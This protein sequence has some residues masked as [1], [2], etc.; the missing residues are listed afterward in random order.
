MFVK[1]Q[2][3][4]AKK[5]IV[6]GLVWL[7]FLGLADASVH[8][9]LSIRLDNVP[10][11]EALESIGR[12]SGVNF[13]IDAAMLRGAAPVTVNIHDQE[14]GRAADRI[15]RPRGFGMDVSGKERVRVVKLEPADEFKAKRDNVFE[16]ARK[17]V[18]T[19]EGKDRVKIEFEVQGWCD[20]TVAIEDSDGRILRHLASGVLG[21]RAPEPFRWNSKAQ[22]L[23][24][25]GKD[26]EGKYVDDKDSVVVRVSLGLKPRFERTLFWSPKKR[27]STTAPLLHAAPEG[28]YVF[29]G[30]GVDHLRLFTHEGEY[31]KTLVPPPAG[32]IPEII[33]LPRHVVPQT[34]RKMP[35]MQGFVQSTLLTSGTS[36]LF[37]AGKVKFG[38]TTAARAMAVQPM[39]GAPSRI[40][41]GF[42]KLNRLA[43]NGTSGGLPF[44]G[45]KIE[46]YT[47]LGGMA[48]PWEGNKKFHMSPSSMAF[49][50]DGS[51]LY[52]TG[53]MWTKSRG[54]GAAYHGVYRLNYETNEK[55]KVFA[56]VMTQDGAGSGDDRFNVP[57]SVA[58]D[59][60]GRVYVSDYLNDRIQV[61]TPDGSLVKSLPVIRPA[62]VSVHAH[63]SEIYAFSWPV[64]GYPYKENGKETT[65]LRKIKPTLTRLG[66]L[67]KPAG[68]PVRQTLPLGHHDSN[69]LY[70]FGQ[71]YSVAL[72]SWAEEPTLWA[73]G[74]RHEV[75]QAAMSWNAGAASGLV[76][77]KWMKYGVR[78]LKE[79]GGK[80]VIK[81]HFGEEAAAKLA[82]ISPPSFAAQRLYF[83]PRNKRLYLGEP[84]G[85]Q[86]SFR[87]LVE[88]DPE[89]GRQRIVQLPFDAEDMAF[90]LNGHAYLRTDKLIARY[91]AA[92]WREIPWDYGEKH[93]G[94]G[95]A[96][97]GGGRSG[98]VISALPLPGGAR[99]VNWSMGGMYVSPKKLLVV[100]VTSKAPNRDLSR[101]LSALRR[102]AKSVYE[103]KKQYEPMAFPGRRRWGEVHVWNKHGELVIEDAAPGLRRLDGIAISDRDHSIYAYAHANRM[104]PDGAPYF[105]GLTGTAM[106]FPRSRVRIRSPHHAV[107]PLQKD[108]QPAR[109]MELDEGWVNGAEWFY[110]GIGFAG[111]NRAAAVI[112]GGCVCWNFRGSFDYFER[113]FLPELD[114]FSVAVVDPAGN[115][116]VRIGDYGN[117]DE[118]VPLVK[119]GGPPDPRS[120]GGDETSFIRPA[121]LATHTDR[122]LFVADYGNARII[123]VKLGYHTEET[124]ALKNMQDGER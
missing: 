73:V 13:I 2:T 39:P 78:I 83:N 116:I 36:A 40:A 56:G 103:E 14:A 8:T 80:W 95:F 89:T 90:D 107:V 38:M 66:T 25:D 58:V 77:R 46:F 98:N 74:R 105:R 119:E 19:R 104:L 94:V 3:A 113:S 123:S 48:G 64:S 11:K 53:Y 81:R 69:H 50:P 121:Y 93:D 108:E 91:D 124:V 122:R 45:P 18:V 75:T 62:K 101:Q 120:I 28:V 31:A 112:G 24:W 102:H 22:K 52:L 10:L 54:G 33:G 117:V 110:G 84:I 26:D 99:P 114:L 41:L 96:R 70:M 12:K 17:P 63:T 15:L 42:I 55:P 92:N 79:E 29:E 76:R 97:G 67:K 111:F 37:E 86:K 88:I 59:K 68:D 44:E 32:T 6:S 109:P 20:A 43:G 49:S 118:G 1:R 23:V 47:K 57:T 35:V 65:K 60:E 72:D 51:H 21:P 5:Y 34:G 30:R 61:F 16:F 115:L 7:V 27:I 100:S 85:F 9:R 4:R 106:K 82:R 71:I 87:D